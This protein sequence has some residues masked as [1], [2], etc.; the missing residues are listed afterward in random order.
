MLFPCPECDREISSRAV[1]CPY[2]GCPISAAEVA[3][4]QQPESRNDPDKSGVSDVSH[5]P[6][7]SRWRTNNP[8]PWARWAARTID[9]FV[10]GVSLTFLIVFVAVAVLPGET[11]N[12]LLSGPLFSNSALAGIMVAVLVVPFIG[13]TIGLWGSS[14]GKWVMGIHVAQVDGTPIGLSR[15]IFRE[16]NVFF[17]GLGMAIPIVTLVTQVMAYKRLKESNNTNWDEANGSVV[18]YL[19]HTWLTRFRAAVGIILTS[20]L[21][22]VLASISP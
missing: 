15:A 1:A 20:I 12:A 13:F 9:T 22:G 17:I 21:A 16:V 18:L 10:V 8:S 19:N 6:P 5:A 14:L 4:M 2:C 3:A 7:P 11:A